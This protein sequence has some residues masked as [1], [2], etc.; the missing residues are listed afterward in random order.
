MN[1]KKQIR[2]DRLRKM[3]NIILHDEKLQ[4][5]IV[6]ICCFGLIVII[7]LYCLLF[8]QVKYMRKYLKTN[9][10]Y[11]NWMNKYKDVYNIIKV[12]ITRKYVVIE[13]E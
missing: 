2:V 1:K 11:F 7:T 12:Y 3:Y 4:N 9:E 13:Y 8:G 6:I 5:L 10:D